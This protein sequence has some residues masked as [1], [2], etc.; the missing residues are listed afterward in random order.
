MA[1]QGATP[2][3]TVRNAIN[4]I[5]AYTTDSHGYIST[6]DLIG[7]IDDLYALLNNLQGR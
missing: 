7:V 6:Y 3:E 5:D 4:I 2:I 1:D